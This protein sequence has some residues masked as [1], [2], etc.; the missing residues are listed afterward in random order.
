M[1]PLRASLFIAFALSAFLSRG[2]TFI[3]T[4]T[5][6]AGAGSL[7]QAILNA[8]AAAGADVIQFNIPGPGTHTISPLSALPTVTGPLLV[9]GTSQPGFAGTPLLELSGDL[10]GITASGFWL[11]AGNSAVVGMVINRFR[12]AGIL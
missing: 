12:N 6:D 7:R 1:Q 5:A 3:V 2:A 9:D 4:N 10:A 8:N 11:T